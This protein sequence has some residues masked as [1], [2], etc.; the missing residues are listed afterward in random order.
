MSTSTTVESAVR[1]YATFTVANMFCGIEVAQ[2]QAHMTLRDTRRHENR[3]KLLPRGLRVR[4]RP[5]WSS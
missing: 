1:R 2:V 3:C 5:F 4:S